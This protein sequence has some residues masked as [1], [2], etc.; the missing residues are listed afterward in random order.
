MKRAS[1]P[2]AVSVLVRCIQGNVT[3]QNRN[4]VGEEGSEVPPLFSVEI[5]R[6]EYVEGG[7]ARRRAY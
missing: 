3:D 2:T 6:E 1:G 7:R 4:G 5:C